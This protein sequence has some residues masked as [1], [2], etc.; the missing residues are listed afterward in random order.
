M[1]QQN[2]ELSKK[3]DLGEVVSDT[4]TFIK[5]NFKPLFKVVLTFCGLFMLAT[6]AAYAMQQLKT[7]ELQRELFNGAG[8]QSFSSP[9]DRFGIEYLLSMLF[10]MLS[11]TLMTL[12]VLSYMALYKQKGNVPPTTEEVWGYIKYYFLR[13]LGGTILLSIL[14]ILATAACIIPG[15]YVY[16]IFGLVFPIMIMEN[17]SF[18]YAFNRSFTIIK[19]NWWLTFG[20]LFVMGL[21]TYVGY[22]I[23]SIPTIIITVVNLFTHGTKTAASSAPLLIVIS[24][25]QQAG[26]ILYVLP[27]IALGFCYYNLTEVKEGSGLIDRINQFGTHNPDS[28]LPAEEY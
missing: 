10:M 14:L 2:I 13:V 5:Q 3:R 15:V 11:Y 22:M 6:A 28:N 23:F 12:T 8:A 4:F 24:L 1:Q 20:T 21:I 17:A 9:L 18:T 26:Q 19:E 7:F 25:I 27:L 16:P